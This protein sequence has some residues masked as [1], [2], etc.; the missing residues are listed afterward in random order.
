[1]SR[2]DERGFTLTEL[3]VTLVIIGLLSSAVVLTMRDPRESLVDGGEAFAARARAAQQLAIAESRD[4]GLW[5]SPEGYG[6]ERYDG[7][8]WLPETQPPLQQRTWPE[9]AAVS[10]AQGAE[11]EA[12]RTRIVFDMTGLNGPLDVALSRDGHTVPVAIGADGSIMVGGND[13]G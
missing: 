3:M 6:F 10:V 12:G 1:M 11:S 9:G 7:E 13:A 8:G 4:I 5:V 2:T